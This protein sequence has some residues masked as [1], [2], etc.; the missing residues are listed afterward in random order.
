MEANRKPTT[1]LC[2]TCRHGELWRKGY[3]CEVARYPSMT[4]KQ[5][6]GYCARQKTMHTCGLCGYAGFDVYV[7]VMANG[8]AVNTMCQDVW[9]CLFRQLAKQPE[10]V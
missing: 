1:S 2:D 6:K 4:K 5:C 9:A 3:F 7:Y 10:K 8:Q